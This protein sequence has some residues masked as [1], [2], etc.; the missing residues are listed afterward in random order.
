[1][2]RKIRG[3]GRG[4]DISAV[5]ELGEGVG[6]GGVDTAGMRR[7]RVEGAERGVSRCPGSPPQS[8][9]ERA[10]SSAR[11]KGK[12][13]NTIKAHLSNSGDEKSGLRLASEG[14]VGGAFSERS[15]AA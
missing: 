13:P 14:P 3:G 5:W 12:G 7:L 8:Q 9:L 4:K 1:M 2:T 6:G 11:G 15:G 10:E